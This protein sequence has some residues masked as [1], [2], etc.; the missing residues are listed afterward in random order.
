MTIQLETDF[1]PPNK[2]TPIVYGRFRVR[3]TLKV[4]F[5]VSENTITN[6]I[7]RFYIE[8]TQDNTV[9]GLSIWFS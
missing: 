8:C 4:V 2:W 7:H 3:Q 9:K 1:L 6:H 5:R